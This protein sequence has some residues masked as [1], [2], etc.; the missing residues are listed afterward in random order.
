[1]GSSKHASDY[2]VT[3]EFVVNH[4]KKTFEHGLDISEALRILKEPD[5]NSWKSKLQVSKL[6]DADDKAGEDRQFSMD[7]KAELDETTRRIRALKG[8]LIKSYALLW[9]RCAKAMQNKIQERSDYQ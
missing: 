4:I 8:N 5:T 9:E 1:M 2:E 3:T 7:Y 6:K